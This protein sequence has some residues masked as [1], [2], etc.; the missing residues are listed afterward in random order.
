MYCFLQETHFS[1]DI[2][3]IHDKYDWFGRSYHS[4]GSTKS[5]GVS[6]LIRNRVIE[7]LNHTSFDNGRSIAVRISYGGETLWLINVYAPNNI[8]IRKQFFEKCFNFIDENVLP[9][10]GVI[11]GGDFNT[12]LDYKLDKEGG[13]L[14][15][16]HF[17]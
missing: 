12:V 4:L 9:G 10:E 3:E 13:I 6:I 2:T 14:K 8:T 1:S 17:I 16:F 11:F 5:C 15:D 7:V